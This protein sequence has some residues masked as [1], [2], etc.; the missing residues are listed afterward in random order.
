MT[1]VLNYSLI[2]DGSGHFKGTIRSKYEEV[3]FSIPAIC[4][5]NGI[6]LKDENIEAAINF[7]NRQN[8]TFAAAITG[9]AI[10]REENPYIFIHNPRTSGTGLSLFLNKC[11]EGKTLRIPSDIP[12]RRSRH[13]NYIEIAQHISLTNPYVFGFVRNP[14]DREYS[15]YSL[16]VK[17]NSLV[18]D[19]RKLNIGTS[20]SDWVINIRDT[21]VW[22]NSNI[23][24]QKSYFVDESNS[25]VCNVFKYEDRTNAME[26]ICN[27]IGGDFEKF[28]LYDTKINSATVDDYKTQYTNEAYDLITQRYAEDLETFGYTFE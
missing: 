21:V 26:T 3:N 7:F 19:E 2:A 4:D 8:E 13:S 15:L 9:N 1:T 27:N 14:Y 20:F 10:Y 16:M 6:L 12:E 25:V 18:F 23:R 22:P 17:M 5:D 24:T 28:K 11:C